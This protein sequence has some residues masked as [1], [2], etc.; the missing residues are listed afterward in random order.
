MKKVMFTAA[1]A[2][3]ATVGAIESAN[4]VGYTADPLPENV[5]KI[6]A[7]SFES[8]SGQSIDI[9]EFASGFT[10]TVSFEDANWQET[11]PAIQIQ[12]RDA[13]GNVTGLLKKY[14]YICD[15]A[16]DD[17][18]NV[19]APGWADDYG[20]YLGSD[21]AEAVTIDPGVAVWFKDPNT[22]STLTLAG[23]VVGESTATSEATANQWNLICN[24]FPTEFS[25][26]SSSITWNGLT[27]TVSFEDEGWQD[28]APAIQIQQRDASGN[29]TG[30]L[31]KYYYI[32]D[33]AKDDDGNVL[34]PGWAD[35]YGC[36]LNSDAAADVTV[37]SGVGFWFKDQ[38]AAVTIQFAR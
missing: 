36:Y 30:L 38:K 18:G 28:T 10:T 33:A 21:A 6:V 22:G 34:A 25:L 8:V 11:A 14:Y 15:A 4:T 29:V 17:D 35:D 27:T 26:N 1:A 31:S 2:L 5:W 7:S 37:K 13:N 23:Q 9:Q 20:C 19:L 16:K 24:P 32:C 12:Q 3:C